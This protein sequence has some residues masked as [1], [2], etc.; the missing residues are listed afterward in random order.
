LFANPSATTAEID[1]RYLPAS[2]TPVSRSYEVEPG[3]RRT[4][5]IQGEDATLAA[6]AVATEVTSNVPIIVERAQ[7]WPDP[8]P[9][10]YEAHNSFGMTAT[11]TRWGLAEGR[12]GMTGNYQTYILLANPNDEEAGVTITFLRENGMTLVKTFTVQPGNRFNVAVGVDV[13]EISSERF[14]AVITATRPIAVERA[15]YSDQGGVTWQA[16]TN[17]IATRLP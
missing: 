10:W 7:Y 6:A 15:M 8:A 12:A 1:V 14:S 16:G 9:N 5:N 13:P 17:A 11:G 3:Q 4:V 2:G